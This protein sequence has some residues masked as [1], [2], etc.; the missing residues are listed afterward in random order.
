MRKLHI[1]CTLQIPKHGGHVGHSAV[2]TRAG[3]RITCT[4]GKWGAKDY[5]SQY[6][7]RCTT[8]NSGPSGL[9]LLSRRTLAF[10]ASCRFIPAHCIGDLA[11][12]EIAAHV[13]QLTRGGAGTADD[14]IDASFHIVIGSRPVAHADAHGGVALPDCASAPAGAFL[15]YGS[16]GCLGLLRRAK[17]D[18]NLIQNNV[19]ENVEASG[20]ESGTE[21][22][23]LAAVAFNY[24]SET[25]TAK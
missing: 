16:D 7:S 20:A 23:S 11:L 17:G 5:A 21:S 9:L 6:T 15:L 18:K 3:C 10:P 25:A 4:G 24:F 2:A 8:Q 14:C 22:L 13:I 19:I 1:P 12:I